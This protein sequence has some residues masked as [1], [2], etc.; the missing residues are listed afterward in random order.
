MTPQ[1]IN[2]E[3]GLGRIDL[4]RSQ[5]LGHLSPKNGRLRF[6]SRNSP[7]VHSV[8]REVNYPHDSARWITGRVTDLVAN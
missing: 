5:I 4:N 2:F 3:T 7:V 6:A 1:P 8:K